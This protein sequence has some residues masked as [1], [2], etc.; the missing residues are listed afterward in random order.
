[1][2]KFAHGGSDGCR[3]YRRYKRGDEPPAKATPYQPVLNPFLIFCTKEG[4]S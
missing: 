1:M 3:V 4:P 2:G